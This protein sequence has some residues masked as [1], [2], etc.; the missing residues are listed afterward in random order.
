LTWQCKCITIHADYPAQ[1]ERTMAAILEAESTLTE[2]YQ[3]TVP[4]MPGWSSASSFWSA[5]YR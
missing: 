5:I 2:R 4:E 1:K 3:T